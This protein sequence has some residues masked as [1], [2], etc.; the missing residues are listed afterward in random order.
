MKGLQNKVEKTR[1]KIKDF[2]IKGIGDILLIQMDEGDWDEELQALLA[3][4]ESR[5][6]FFTSAKIAIE[7]GERKVKAVQMADLRDGLAEQQVNLVALF[8]KSKLTITTARTF[9]LETEPENIRTINGN[10]I[11]DI[12]YGGE[13]AKLFA[14][15]LRSGMKVSYQGSVVVIGDV[16]PGAEIIADGNV[17]VWG[18][19]RGKV[20]AGAKGNEKAVICAM[21]M[22]ATRVQIADTEAKKSVQQ[23]K[24]VK[25]NCQNSEL[26]FTNWKH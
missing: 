24:P 17:I 12:L 13:N 19:V 26:F 14:H 23:S 5:K 1:T 6:D 2:R 20:T 11:E 25:I 21:E 3:Y 22:K 4:I 18:C 15:T 8:S 10:K 9:G 16:N 7:V